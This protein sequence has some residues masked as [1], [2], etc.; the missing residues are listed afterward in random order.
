MSE[1]KPQKLVGRYALFSEL[2]SGGMA[3]VHLARLLGEAGFARTVAVKRLHPNYAKDKEFVSMFLDEAR[4]AARIRHPNV[5][6]VLDIVAADDELLLVMEF[7]QGEALSSLLRLQAGRPVVPS[8]A[9]K[10]AC[11]L[12][13]GLHAAH[14]ARNER[15]EP[16]EIVHRDVSPQNL[17]VGLDGVSRVTDFGIAKASNR[18]QTTREGQLKGKLAYMSPEQFRERPVDRRSDVYAASIVL[19]EMLAGRRLF[20]KND[21]GATVNNILR[22]AKTPPSA[23]VNAVPKELDLIVMRGLAVDPAKRYA[24]AQDMAVAMERAFRPAP[25]ADV[26]AWVEEL[27]EASLSERV[28]L[29]AGLESV[30]TVSGVEAARAYASR[31]SVSED[32]LDT[33]RTS[34]PGVS[35]PVNSNLSSANVA[36][37]MR[38][39]PPIQRRAL[40]FAAAALA[41]VFGVVAIVIIVVVRVRAA[42][43]SVEAAAPDPVRELQSPATG[44]ATA[45][46]PAVRG[47]P[48]A[49]DTPPNEILNVDGADASVQGRTSPPANARPPAPTARRPTPRPAPKSTSTKPAP[50]PTTGFGSLS[51]E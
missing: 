45:T 2:A 22:G 10:V 13:Y 32:Q 47:G 11:D 17:L 4:L 26:G 41:C 31:L 21:P 24:T 50:K 36:R 44:P 1:P 48:S 9:A 12:L 49:A 20:A 27:A 33:G 29:L 38:P 30:S 43:P 28:A 6:P 14:D 51:R 23:Y 16:L 42:E 18:I 5:V 37:S 19:W 35:E 34:H 46:S 39:G 40:W 15:G 25:A 7:V 8:I 3:T